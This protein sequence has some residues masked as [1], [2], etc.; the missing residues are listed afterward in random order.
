MI[1][2][3]WGKRAYLIEFRDNN[4]QSTTES[5]TFAVPPESEEFTFPKRYSETKTF[6]GSV[7]EDYGNDTVRITLSGSTVNEELKYIGNELMSGE[8]EIFHLQK[9]L[10]TYGKPE[11]LGKRQIA[12]YC[13]ESQDKGIKWFDVIVADFQIRRSKDRPIAYTYTL[14]LLGTKKEPVQAEE[15]LNRFDKFEKTV[16]GWIEVIDQ[17]SQWLAGGMEHLRDALDKIAR[18]QALTKSFTASIKKYVDVINGYIG[19]TTSI[20][21]SSL[22]LGATVV[23]EAERI[24]LGSGLDV[25]NEVKELNEAVV[26]VVDYVR[27]FDE[28]TI[29]Q[30]LLEQYG[31]TA[32]DIAD[33]WKVVASEMESASAHTVATTRMECSKV[34][35]SVVPGGTGNDDRVVVVYGSKMHRATAADTWDR[36]ALEYLG[37]TSLGQMIAMFNDTGEIRA[38]DMVNIPVINQQDS[39]KGNAIYPVAG[40]IDNYGRDIE[41]NASGDLADFHGD[42]GIASKQDNLS[43]A[44]ESRLNTAVDSRIRLQ[45]YGIRSNIGNSSQAQN[46]IVSS[47]SRTLDEE[48][49]IK[50]VDKINYDGTGDTLKLSIHYTDV[51]GLHQAYGGTV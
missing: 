51:N 5:F 21:Q 29:S 38:G 20:V 35:Y 16:Q 26:D 3:S 44:I 23:R 9:L 37:D 31:K 6:G 19:L 11:E 50:S 41:I 39:V 42:L 33:A 43:Q 45:V 7:F 27:N 10:E 8:D 22:K 47:V 40:E 24:T 17:G 34:N 2:K 4:T 13:L 46:F 30:D 32:S 49:R 48:P 18:V 15:L 1:D 28:K 12:I 14:S 36:L 25:L